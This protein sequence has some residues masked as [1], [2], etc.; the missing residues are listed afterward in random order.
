MGRIEFLDW[1]YHHLRAKHFLYAAEV[2]NRCCSWSS[3]NS[4]SRVRYWLKYGIK[5][6]GDYSANKY[7]Y[8]YIGA[9]VNIDQLKYA[10]DL[11]EKELKNKEVF[12]EKKIRSEND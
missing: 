3:K 9:N 1:V 10:F 11:I 12:F 4:I 8:F 7:I 2:V 5:H 6:N